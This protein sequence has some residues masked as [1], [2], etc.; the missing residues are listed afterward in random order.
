MQKG[1]TNIAS[2]IESSDEESSSDSYDISDNAEMID[3]IANGP[4]EDQSQESTSSTIVTPLN[5]HPRSNVASHVPTPT[6][7][8]LP[9]DEPLANKPHVKDFTPFQ[10]QA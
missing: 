4:N 5:E 8:D 2:A 6:T 7:I 10:T 1:L 9:P 3:G